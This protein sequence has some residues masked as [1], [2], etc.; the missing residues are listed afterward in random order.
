M[1]GQHVYF[2]FSLC[3]FNTSELII[4]WHGFSITDIIVVIFLHQRF[5]ELILLRIGAFYTEL[6]LCYAGYSDDL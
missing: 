4:A 3:N 1:E 2:S 6:E 5:P